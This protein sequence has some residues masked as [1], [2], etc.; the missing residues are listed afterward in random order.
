MKNFIKSFVGFL[1]LMAFSFNSVAQEQQLETTRGNK[2]LYGIEK[3]K[4]TTD[5]TL[6][7]ADSVV[8]ADNTGGLVELTIVGHSAAGDAITGK[9]IYRYKKASGTLTLGSAANTSATVVDAGL[10]TSTY[11]FA[12]TATGNLQ[13]KIKGKLSTSVKWRWRIQ[14]VYP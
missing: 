4:T 13:L 14:R 11:T 5:S 7:H 3:T 1:I 12:G 2:V 6:A 9:H 8:V 10:G